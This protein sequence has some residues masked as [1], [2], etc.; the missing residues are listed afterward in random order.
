[1]KA[2]LI[3]LAIISVGLAVF[4]IVPLI[5]GIPDDPQ[6]SVTLSDLGYFWRDGGGMDAHGKIRNDAPEQI[7]SIRI[8]FSIHDRDG[9]KIGT[10]S[11]YI[12][13]LAPGETWKFKAQSFE[14]AA[15]SA[16]LD[17]VVVDHKR[18]MVSVVGK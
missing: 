4:V 13:G 10:A 11:D 7:R 9:N 2:I 15:Y 5:V 14:D 8:R 6:P 16:T 1:M 17:G 18:A 3:I 12:T